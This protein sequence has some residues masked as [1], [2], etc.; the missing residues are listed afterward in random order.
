MSLPF[1]RK[2][3]AFVERD[4]PVERAL[5]DHPQLAIVLDQE[6]I[7]QVPGL[8]QH[9]HDLADRAGASPNSTAEMMLFSNPM[10]EIFEVDECSSLQCDR[11]GIGVEM[12]SGIGENVPARPGE[13]SRLGYT[14]APY[15]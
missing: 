4:V 7:G 6:R 9:R 10:I 5:R 15:H 2:P 8:L 3:N 14:P 13:I 11:E 12:V 1:V